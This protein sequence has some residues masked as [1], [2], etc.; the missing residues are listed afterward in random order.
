MANKVKTLDAANILTALGISGDAFGYRGSVKDF[1]EAVK[2]GFYNVVKS[3]AD[4]PGAPAGAYGYGLLVVLGDI[5]HTW[6]FGAQIYIPD[7]LNENPIYIRNKYVGTTAGV[8]SFG[9]WQ[10]IALSPIGGGNKR[11][12]SVLTLFALA[13]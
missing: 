7:R 11:S 2:P 6:D 9:A 4:I 10:K 13:A 8:I 5:T 12:F 1:N 3:G